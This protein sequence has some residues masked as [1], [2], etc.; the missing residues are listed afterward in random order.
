MTFPMKREM[1]R[2]EEKIYLANV[3]YHGGGRRK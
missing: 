2:G 3:P 1:E